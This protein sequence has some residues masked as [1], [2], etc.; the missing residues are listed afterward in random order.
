MNILFIGPY[1][2]LDSWGRKSNAMLQQLKKTDNSITARPIFLSSDTFYN[3]YIEEAES[4]QH[5]NYDILIQ[6]VLE[7]YA[8]HFGKFKK[9]IG[10]F[11]NDTLPTITNIANLTGPLLM[12]EIWTENK[13]LTNRLD[14]LLHEHNP[15]IKIKTISPLLEVD[16]LPTQSEKQFRGSDLENRFLFYFMGNPLDDKSGFKEAFTAYLS[17]FNN[18]DLVS[19]I[20]ALDQQLPPETLTKK[21]EEH[22][23]CINAF[24]PKL[25]HPD[26]RIIAP[27]EAVI[28]M[29]ERIAIHIDSDCMVCPHYSISTDLRS[30]EACLYKST[31]IVSKHS[32]IYNW[33]GEQHLWG[34]DSY[35]DMCITSEGL[36]SRFTVAETWHKPIV[37]SLADTMKKCYINKFERDKKQ[38]A[39]TS[40]R[41]TLNEHYSQTLQEVLV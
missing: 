15:N 20:I 40:I 7:P 10:I 3:S 28:N 11:N 9:N 14:N 21:L 38:L 2:Q 16:S 41:N 33:L 24:K 39:N 13:D 12:D 6:Y 30:I 23:M 31:P 26:V 37:R 29:Q 27:S 19:F 4:V 17:T 8:T 22:S 35:E 18:K 1:R 5:S 34:V 36:L 32:T 25:H